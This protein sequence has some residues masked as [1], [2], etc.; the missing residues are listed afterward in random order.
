MIISLVAK[1][2]SD[3]IKHPF[4]V[5]VL[6]RLG[7][8]S[9]YVNMIKAIYSTPVANIKVIREKL[10]TIPLKSGTR[11]CCQLS[12]NLFNIVFEVLARAI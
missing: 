11:Q 12:P 6:E 7:S 5:K 8:R 2:A 4:M 3:K 10:E 9:P 1:K